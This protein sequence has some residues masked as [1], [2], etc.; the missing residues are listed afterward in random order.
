M[1]DPALLSR[2]H[3]SG[4]ARYLLKV[5]TSAAAEDYAKYERLREAIWECPD[6]HLA[7][8]RNMMCENFVHDGSS[9]FIA[10]YAAG[11]DGRFEETSAALAGFSYGFVG[12]KDKAVGFKALDNIW[13]YSQY[14]GVRSEAQ[15]A[16]LGVAIKE[17]QRDILLR[18]YGIGTVVCTYDPLTGVNALRNIGRF[19]MAVLEYRVAAYGEF[20]GRLNRADVPSDRFFMSWDLKAE[21]PRSVEDGEEPVLTVPSTIAVG[22]TTVCGRTRV[23]KLETAGGFDPAMESDLLAVPIPLDYYTMLRETD[24]DDPAVRRIPVDWRLATREAFRTLLARGFRV[25]DF[26]RVRHPEPGNAYLLGRE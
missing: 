4:T 11:P 9:L 1:A 2:I 15:G 5:E 23:L 22:Q 24:V 13:F 26:R 14:A 6:D 25:V 20:G 3:V 17:F 21:E 10:A 18:V 12:V 16:G 8:P 7:G 19:G